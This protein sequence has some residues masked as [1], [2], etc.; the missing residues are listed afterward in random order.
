MAAVWTHDLGRY[1]IEKYMCKGTLKI[2]VKDSAR[3]VSEELE[4][5]VDN[6]LF[7]DNIN[8]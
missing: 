5:R 4:K 3:D 1:A 6:K 7:P 8:L 2:N